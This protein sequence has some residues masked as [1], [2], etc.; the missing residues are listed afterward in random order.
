MF[1]ELK[2]HLHKFRIFICWK[3]ILAIKIDVITFKQD[4][5][6]DYLDGLG[7]DDEA[8]LILAEVR[9]IKYILY[10]KLFVLGS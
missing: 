3:T 7:E 10:I 2:L 6:C 1:L 5:L 9:S 4:D 8:A